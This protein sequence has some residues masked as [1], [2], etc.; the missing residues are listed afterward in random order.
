MT[1][2]ICHHVVSRQLDTESYPEKVFTWQQAYGPI[3]RRSLKMLG[4][5]LR[6]GAVWNNTSSSSQAIAG[7]A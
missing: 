1:P 2:S 7:L 3:L 5:V 6:S 4:I